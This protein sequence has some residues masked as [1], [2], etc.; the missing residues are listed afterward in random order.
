MT[1]M[2]QCFLDGV[3]VV[4]SSPPKSFIRLAAIDASTHVPGND[5]YQKVVLPHQRLAII[6]G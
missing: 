5:A 2:L 1:K 6:S 4:T 3:S